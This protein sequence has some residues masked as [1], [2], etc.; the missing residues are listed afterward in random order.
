MNKNQFG[1]SSVIALIAAGAIILAA[2]QVNHS[3]DLKKQEAKLSESKIVTPVQKS[4]NPEELKTQTNQIQKYLVAEAALLGVA[5][6]ISLYFKDLKQENPLEVSMEPTKSWVPASTI[7]AY[8]LLE[9][10]RQKRL[11]LISFDQPVTISADNVV[12]TELET[13]EFPRLREDTSV[14]VKQLVEAMIIQSDNS[15]YNTLLDILD[16][17]NINSSLR[18]IGITETVVGEK[19][20]LDADQFQKDL[21]STGRQPNTTTVKDL[22]TYFSL[23]YSHKIPDAEEI[24]AV[25]KRQK[26]NN[27]IPARLPENTVVAHKTGDWAP[28][29]HDG[30]I[31]YKPDDPFVLAIFTSDGDPS[32]VAKLA[33]VAYYQDAKYVGKS[34]ATG[35]LPRRNLALNTRPVYYASQNVQVLGESTPSKFPDITAQDLGITTK[36]L[37]PDLRQVN[38]VQ[39]ALVN[40]GS[41]LY[42]VKKG[43]ENVS[44]GLSFT[45][46]QK[47]K[48]HLNL[49]NS[50]LSEVKAVLSRGELGNTQTLL[51]EATDE[52]KNATEM[53]KNTP[54]QDNLLIQI[55]RTN[56]MYY[57]VMSDRADS[58]P[59]DKKAQFVDSVYNF[60]QKGKKEISPLI[61]SSVI[62]SPTQQKPTVGVI[63]SVSSDKV[64]LKF[65][66]GSTR[67]V[68]ISPATNVRAVDQETS[69]D[70]NTLKKGNK[71]AVLGP[72]GGNNAINAQF[73]LNDIPKG[74]TDQHQGTVTEVDPN[75][76]TLKV[77]DQKGQVNLVKVDQNTELRAKD[78][79]VSLEGVKTG[80]KVVIFGIPT[81][82]L[83][84]SGSAGATVTPTSNN[85]QGP[86]TTVKPNPSPS[87][88][89]GQSSGSFGG[90][91]DKGNLISPKLQT[92]PANPPGKSAPTSSARQTN[93]PTV[94]PPS[95]TQPVNG[96]PVLEL[97]AT[98]VT[99]VGNSSG[100]TE[101]KK[102]APSTA[103]P[104]PPPP[105]APAQPKTSSP[106]PPSSK[107]ED[108][109]TTK[110]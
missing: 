101:Q 86:L 55:K 88:Q 35:N 98:S 109:Q 72:T 92:N 23:L 13:D 75:S 15:A 79:N 91:T 26:I 1:F 48:T 50:R 25:F 78:T 6:N 19:L 102:P 4:N 84:G 40:P 33:Q 3:I 83:E 41:V 95:I 100:K 99:V 34:V 30:G 61:N 28:I 96:K 103:P 53:A 94:A 82:P 107:T 11:G 64:T 12:P 77:I 69:E 54:D 10:F 21:L 43:L 8:V 27:M 76:Q 90:N 58:L 20:N 56:D 68:N 9:A 73:I 104:P 31:V 18:N 5:D 24:L 106:P 39:G 51:D 47:S 60:Y 44:L 81:A 87:P 89:Q 70:L 17:R 62:A 16:R 45:K 29:Y 37:M 32:V 105:S 65:D 2:I 22:A 108:K 59:D 49:A 36:D 14:T 63:D 42:S 71:V 46:E 85:N 57:A 97:K 38:N 80:S 66:D 110:K 74:L 67:Q 93:S 7:K 52:I